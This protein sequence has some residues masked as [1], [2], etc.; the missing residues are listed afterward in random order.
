MISDRELPAAID[1]TNEAN[2]RAMDLQIRLLAF[3][4]PWV[5]KKVE[6]ADGTLLQKVQTGL[7]EY[8][9]ELPCTP[10]V[11]VYRSSSAY[12]MDWTVKVSKSYGEGMGGG[13]TYATATVHVGELQGDTLVKLGSPITLRTDYTLE[14]VRAARKKAADLKKAYEDARSECHPFGEW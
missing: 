7:K 3:F 2:R 12:S 6:K 13:T 1:A 10:S 9:G 4:T 5:G 11:H 8:I 14:N